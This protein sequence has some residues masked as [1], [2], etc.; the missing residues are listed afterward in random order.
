MEPVSLLETRNLVKEYHAR[1]VV[2]QV[3]LQVRNG[4]IVGLLG[5]N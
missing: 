2:D 1:R 5:P 3:N 4:S